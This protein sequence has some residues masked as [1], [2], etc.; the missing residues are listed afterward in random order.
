MSEIARRLAARGDD[1]IL[2]ASAFPGSLRTE[3]IDGVEVH[4][5]G[6]LYTV[7]LRAYLKYVRLWRE[8]ADIILEEAIGASR[9]PFAAPLYARVPT[10]AVWY[11]DNERI[12]RHQ[13]GRVLGLCLAVMQRWVAIVHRESY[14]ITLSEASKS[15]LVRM[16]FS[17]G[18]VKVSYPGLH[19]SLLELAAHPN[20][21][22]R[23]LVIVAMGKIRKYKCFHLAIHVL[24]K[25][26]SELPQARLVIAGRSEDTGYQTYLR[27]LA[28]RL[29]V[30]DAVSIETD[31]PE[32]RKAALLSSSRVL[33]IPSPIEGFGLTAIEAN[34]FGLP[35]VASDG[36]PHDVVREGMTGFRVP[37]GDVDAFAK[38]CRILMTDNS[39]FARMSQVCRSYAQKFTWDGSMQPVFET[40]DQAYQLWKS[41]KYAKR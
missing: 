12:F 14:I 37:F 10:V 26:R 3:I 36:V 27:K 4:R 23:E 33:L 5:A 20:E 29:R 2:F 25:V 17:P 8:W 21:D 40:V 9:I 31:I 38:T 41:G 24:A 19:P 6:S 16:G 15:D 39:A 28:S 1:V 30:S 13:Y 7:A 22:R 35:V 11:Q 18:R 32:E 34:A